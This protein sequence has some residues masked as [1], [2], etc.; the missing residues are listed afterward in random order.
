LHLPDTFVP[1]A[2]YVAVGNHHLL[3]LADHRTF[4]ICTRRPRG[5]VKS[6]EQDGSFL[7]MI[8][9]HFIRTYPVAVGTSSEKLWFLERQG[10]CQPLRE[11]LVFKQGPTL[12]F[13]RDGKH[14]MALAKYCHPNPRDEA[15]CLCWITMAA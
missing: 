6:G 2:N 13:F 8:N 3:W 12:L 15:E 5:W 11:V 10:M 1:S 9:S 14:A 7:T 4:S